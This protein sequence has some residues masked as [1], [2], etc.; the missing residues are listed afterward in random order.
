M[1]KKKSLGKCHQ[2]TLM[3]IP[4][5]SGILKKICFFCFSISTFVDQNSTFWAI[6]ILSTGLTFLKLWVEQYL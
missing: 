6:E 3:W 2:V 1:D 5:H 4:N